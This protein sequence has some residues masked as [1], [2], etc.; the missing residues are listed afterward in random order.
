MAAMAQDGA[1][2][3][4][5]LSVTEIDRIYDP[6]KEQVSESCSRQ[7]ALLAAVQVGFSVITVTVDGSVMSTFQCKSYNYCF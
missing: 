7:E 2:D 5:S 1:I 3:E 6:L 4:H